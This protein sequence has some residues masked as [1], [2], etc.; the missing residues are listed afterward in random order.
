M[1][2]IDP[3]TTRMAAEAGEAAAVVARQRGA[4]ADAVRSLVATLRARPP[5]LVA[6]MARGS[7]DH[8]T[9]FLRYLVETRI[10]VPAASMAPSVASLYGASP[11]LSGALAVA[12]SQ[13]GASPDLL[14]SIGAARAVGATTL[15]LVNV[16][17]SPLAGAV[18]RVLPLRAGPERSVAATKSAIATLAQA[19]DLIAEWSDDADL[20]AAV[21]DL[22]GALAG[23]WAADW[24]ALVDL[25]HPA[26]GLF[27]IG[28]GPALGIAQEMALKLKETCG[29]HAEAFSAAEVRHGPMALVGPG[30]PVLIL[31]QQDESADG[32]DALAAELAARGGDV[33]LA[34][35]RAVP[36]TIAL[37]LAPAAGPG[38]TP[39]AARLHPVIA[40]IA[41]LQS[42]YRAANALS[43]ARGH[44]PDR[45]PFLHKV[46]ETI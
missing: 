21:A 35:A 27:V 39:V 6:T 15:A 17:D 20:R 12:V 36:G 22:P 10:G 14:A 9:T 7:S 1:T 29:L 38:A 11:D 30:F 45:P 41:Q 43:V 8:A 25:L 3:A 26:T 40:P 46:T 34:G 28:R 33:L 13:S 37:P 24:S 2:A 16:A 44:D 5:R 32:V 18:D 42:F 4:N 19:A 23:A 31:R